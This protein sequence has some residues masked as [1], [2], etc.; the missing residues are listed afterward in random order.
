MK[1]CENILLLI[2]QF[3]H[4]KKFISLLFVWLQ[5]AITETKESLIDG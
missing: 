5:N 3:P 1:I 2:H 4:Y